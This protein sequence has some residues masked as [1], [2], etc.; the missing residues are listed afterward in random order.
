M[1]PARQIAEFVA[2][3]DYTSIPSAALAA[4]KDAI[5]DSIGVALAGGR[6]PAG[7]IPGDLAREEHATEEA[8]V[9]GQG[10]RSSATNAAFV[11]G[12]STHALDFD[13]SF[14]IMGQPM[15]GLPATVLALAEATGANGQQ[16]LAGYVVGFE[17][18]AKVA[19]ALP[20]AWS[21][22]A[23]H[24][25]A[26]VG[27]V[28]CTAAAAKLLGLDLEQTAMA[29]GLVCSMASG[30]IG[31]F[32]TMGKPL[33]AGLGARNGVTAA[34]LAQRGFTGNPLAL[35]ATNGFFDA[36][37]PSEAPDLEPIGNLGTKFDLAQGAVR[38]K[39]YPCGGLTHAAIDAVLALRTEHG[40]TADTVDGID[41]QVSPFTASRII[42]RIPETGLQGK[43]SMPYILARALIDGRLTPDTFSDTAARDRAVLG[44][45]ERVHMEGSSELD[46]DASGKRPARVSIRL[47]NG[48]ILFRQVDYP[49]GSPEAPLTADELRAKFTDC[50][51]PALGPEAAG[52]AI[53]MLDRLDTVDSV[54]R[55]AQLLAGPA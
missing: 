12:T 34:R 23:W 33:H 21:D 52:Q 9:L 19:W 5:L 17:V 15:A 14:P 16:L 42:Y 36:F 47:K 20:G 35:N 4:A 38:F 24:S 3:T 7:R 28:G 26:T 45:A 39:A 37:V 29:I 25:P 49:K 46:H 43:F 1:E 13:A 53:S 2:Q 50:A 41:V 44:L 31:N 32:G 10:F 11:N 48:Q 40:L 30:V 55:L 51:E 18:A 54:A 27:S 6:E 22:S 8:T